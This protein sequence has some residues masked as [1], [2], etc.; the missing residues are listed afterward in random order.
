MMDENTIAQRLD[1]LMELQTR[2]TDT[3]LK[4]HEQNARQLSQVMLV[5]KDLGAT[6]REMQDELAKKPDADDLKDAVTQVHK[7]FN[8]LERDLEGSFG[9]VGAAIGGAEGNVRN[10]VITAANKLWDAIADLSVQVENRTTER[11][12]ELKKEISDSEERL[13]W[14]VDSKFGG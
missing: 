7:R 10:E 13:K 14:N 8:S 2:N 11:L 3:L 9:S 5:L 4:L 1:K 12:R 6:I